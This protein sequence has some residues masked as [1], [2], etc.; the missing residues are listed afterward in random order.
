MGF[1]SF[2]HK[3]SHG[4]KN[5]FHKIDHGANNF[6]H[7]TVPGIAKKVGGGLEQAGGVINTGLR[8]VG[9]TLE[10]NSAIL[11]DVGAGLAM[12]LGQPELAAISLTAGNAGQQLGSN[13]KSV[14][15]RVNNAVSTAQS[16]I[17]RG[18]NKSQSMVGDVRGR[19]GTGL[20]SLDNRLNMARDAVRSYNSGMSQSIQPN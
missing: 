15:G 5:F 9:N 14:R 10:K 12:A 3:I 8:K 1:G 4:A 17:N 16:Q 2:F 18:V 11:G 20:G 6:F 13:I 7:K 19:V